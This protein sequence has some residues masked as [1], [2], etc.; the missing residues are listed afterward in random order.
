M[1]SALLSAVACA[2]VVLASC[3][4]SGAM[5][6]GE[7]V[8]VSTVVRTRGLDASPGT[9]RIDVID[10]IECYIDR[11]GCA[12]MLAAPA[13]RR[14][15]TEEELSRAFARFENEI[16]LEDSVRAA[17]IRDA[18]MGNLLW[19][20]ERNCGLYLSRLRGW[21]VTHRSALGLAE[22]A[23]D[24][25]GAIT[26]NEATSR[27]MSGLSGVA[28]SVS[29]RIDSEVFASTAVELTTAQIEASMDQMRDS[30]RQ[31]FNTPYDQWRLGAAVRDIEAL[32][33]HC[34]MRVGLAR[35]RQSG[36]LSSAD[37]EFGAARDTVREN[38][39]ANL[40][41]LLGQEAD[42]AELAVETLNARAVA[43]RER[44]GEAGVSTAEHD[45]LIA[46]AREAEAES[47]AELRRAQRARADIQRYGRPDAATEEGVPP[48]APTVPEPA[49]DDPT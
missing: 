23:V 35:L 1:K 34:D 18:I 37:T 20:S 21:Q 40:I 11:T 39:T 9:M 24:A 33:Q 16:G 25:A 8:D 2:C 32:H 31:K 5:L 27:L 41:R 17:Q 3:Q 43:W 47:R 7:A 19:A 4:Q 15:R 36:A 13:A 6:S 29:G 49:D 44:A 45:A 28:T 30:I 42:R 26:T 22:I 12:P 46:Q 14:I 10:Q 48:P 38:S